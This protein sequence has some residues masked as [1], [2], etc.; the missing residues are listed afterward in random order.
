MARRKPVWLQKREYDIAKARETYYETRVPTQSTTVRPRPLDKAVYRSYLITNAGTSANFK[1]PVSSAAVTFFGGL[2]P[3]GLVAITGFADPVSESPRNFA[4]AKVH[5][6][7]ADATPT[8]RIT[9][10]GSRVIKYS[11][12][13]EGTAQAHYSAPISSG[14]ASATYDEIDSK[15][16]A[17]FTAIKSSLGDQNYAKFYVTPEKYSNSKK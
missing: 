16:T 9:P 7:K 14:D 15:A 4:P 5:A 2:T 13:T 11:A 17:L 1:V 3:L 8:A 10:W 12:T 6:M